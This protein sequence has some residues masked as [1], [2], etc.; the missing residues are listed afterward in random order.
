MYGGGEE[1]RGRKRVKGDKYE[2]SGIRGLRGG[3]KASGGGLE[4]GA[5]RK[6]RRA[7]KEARWE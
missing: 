2:L 1:E 4:L 3:K 5:R 6:Q 7:T